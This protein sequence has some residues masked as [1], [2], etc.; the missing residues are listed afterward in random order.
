[1]VVAG[2]NFVAVTAIV[3]HIGPGMPPA[4]GAFLRY[5]LGLVFVLPMLVPMLR[6][7]LDRRSMILFGWRGLVHAGG[8]I[9]WFFA[10]TK[11]AITEVTALNYLAPVY[12]TIG[13]VIF[14]GERLAYRRILAVVAALI[15]ALIILRPGFREVS[16][17]HLAMLAA[18]VFFAASYLLAKRLSDSMNASVIVGML[19]VTVPF[20]LLPFA[21]AVWVPPTSEQLLL[22]FLVAFFA[23]AGHYTMTLAFRNAPVSATQPA[24]FLQLVWASLL[25]TLVFSEPADAWVLT[26]G[27]VIIASVSFI[28]WR[29]AV[30]ALSRGSSNAQKE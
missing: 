14:L 24:L 27:T 2:L 22:L 25:G 4:Q 29:E 20:A 10:M 3:K 6:A 8:V 12:V 17:G 11:I 18:A 1:M 16:Q 28:A 26:G 7:G 13:A 9:L 21:A 19:S 23:T 5:L 30:V 15:G